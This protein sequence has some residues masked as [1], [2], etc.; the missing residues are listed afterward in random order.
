MPGKRRYDDDDDYV[1]IYDL[2][3]D[4]EEDLD[5]ELDDEL[6]EEDLLDRYESPIV[7]NYDEDDE[8]EDEEEEENDFL[9]DGFHYAEDEDEDTDY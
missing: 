7:L 6:D 4:K 8:F 3:D 1:S 9:D 2:T 5:D